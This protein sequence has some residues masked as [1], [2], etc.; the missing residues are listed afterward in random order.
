MLVKSVVC[1]LTELPHIC[2]GSLPSSN[3]RSLDLLN[4]IGNTFR[5]K[6]LEFSLR[7]ARCMHTEASSHCCAL[8]KA[9]GL[10]LG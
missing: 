2:I 1:E 3:S 7:I 5:Q 4:K 10:A 8:V 9:N 6:A